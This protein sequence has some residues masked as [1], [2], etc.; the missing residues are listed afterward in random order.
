MLH[1][2]TLKV[3]TNGDLIYLTFPSLC[4]PG[5]TAAFSTRM[6]GYSR[7][8]FAQMNLSFT[9]GDSRE[10]VLKNYEVLLGAL[11]L[12]P[13]RAVLSHQTHT[14]RLRVVTKADIGKGIVKPR[15]Y[16]NIDGLITNLPGVPLV[17]QYADCV[18]LLFFDPVK[19]V[20]AAAHAGW[21]GTVQEIGVKTVQKMQA[22]FGC[23][24]ADIHAAIGPSIGPCCYEVDRPVIKA[25]CALSYLAPEQVLTPV[26]AT[27]QKLNL[28]QTNAL[29]LQHAGIL[30]QNLTVSDLCTCCNSNYFHS[31]RATGGSRGNLAAVIALTE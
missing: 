31:H 1:S 22:E 15:D 29:I 24:P 21:R 6:G 20:V 25:V 27:H 23:C 8:R 16:E 3:V 13:K 14:N 9:N 17:T 28:Q 11:K 4:V 30:P 10:T 18:P 7:G 2:K 5:V 12:N 26:D 19:R